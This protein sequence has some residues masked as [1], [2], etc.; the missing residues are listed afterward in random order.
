MSE[1]LRG[2]GFA[3]AAQRF[4]YMGTIVV[5]GISDISRVIVTVIH[6]SIA[7]I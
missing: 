5:K 1:S 6:I 4:I 7:P 3:K 2:L